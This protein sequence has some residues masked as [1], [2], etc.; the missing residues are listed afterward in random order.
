MTSR[1]VLDEAARGDTD[2]AKRR[3]EMLADIPI[4]DPNPDVKT[5]ADEIVARS[6]IPES[7]T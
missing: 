4:L 7:A 5:I 2:V 3:L 6:L 1:L